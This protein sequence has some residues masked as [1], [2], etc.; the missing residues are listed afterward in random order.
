MF[1]P[2]FVPGGLVTPRRLS[3]G[4]TRDGLPLDSVAVPAGVVAQ[5]RKSLHS[6]AA[7]VRAF[8]LKAAGCLTW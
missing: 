7:G 4:E 3:G 2:F 8:W 1:P 5:G 6:N